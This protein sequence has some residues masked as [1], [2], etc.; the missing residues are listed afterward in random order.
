MSSPC[1]A[2]HEWLQVA[3]SARRSQGRKPAAVTRVSSYGEAVAVIAQWD[4][5]RGSVLA[6]Y[7]ENEMAVDTAPPESPTT[8]PPDSANHTHHQ[9]NH[10]IDMKI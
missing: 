10:A 5:E 9:A 3:C 4:R 2:S 8:A 6:A 7:G 1:G